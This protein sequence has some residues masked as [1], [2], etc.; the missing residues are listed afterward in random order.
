[1]RPDTVGPVTMTVTLE[2]PE[3]GVIDSVT[4]EQTLGTHPDCD[5][6]AGHDWSHDSTWGHGGG[7]IV[8]ETCRHCGLQKVTDSWDQDWTGTGEPVDTITY[9]EAG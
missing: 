8:T 7:V 5:G 2:D 9:S 6:P 3:E 1:M 4:L